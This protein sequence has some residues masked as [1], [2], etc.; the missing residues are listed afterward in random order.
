MSKKF[1]LNQVNLTYERPESV[2]TLSN[3]YNCLKEKSFI[4][5]ILSKIKNRNDGLFVEIGGGAGIHGIILKSSFGDDYIHTDYSKAMVEKAISLGLKS[6]CVDGLS[7]PFDNNVLSTIF[8]V[9]STTIIRSK[10]LRLKQFE[11][12]Y[13][14][15]ETNGLLIM[16]TSR[17]GF[18]KGQ[19]CL[20]AI[21]MDELRK[22]GFKIEEIACWGIIP[23]KFWHRLLVSVFSKLEIIGSALGLGIRKIVIARKN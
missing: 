12:C 21:D 18:L 6:L 17:S 13:R 8:N 22:I 11:E 16:V 20:D 1:D 23:G 15:L 7:I 10:D 19:H 3:W 2:L 5:F 14:V 4:D 9:G